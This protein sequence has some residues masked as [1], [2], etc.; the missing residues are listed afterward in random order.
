MANKVVGS[1]GKEGLKHLLHSSTE[2]KLSVLRSFINELA[3]APLQAA[4]CG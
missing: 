2:E 3:V 4:F 1:A